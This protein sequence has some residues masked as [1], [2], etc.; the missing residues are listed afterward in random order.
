MATPPWPIA[1]DAQVV[2]AWTDEHQKERAPH[3]F[4]P[5]PRYVLAKELIPIHLE[6]WE[7]LA[8]RF[9]CVVAVDSLK[10]LYPCC[11]PSNGADAGHYDQNNPECNELKAENSVFNDKLLPSTGLHQGRVTKIILNELI[12]R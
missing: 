2:A 1:P 10:C 4:H 7:D 12:N 5:S 6:G 9:P 11:P 3:W 8:H